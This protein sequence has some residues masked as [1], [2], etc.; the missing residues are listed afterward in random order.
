[1]LAAASARIGIATA[2]LFPTVS[3]SGRFGIGAA[4]PSDLVAAGAPFFSI[5]PSITW[6]LFDRGM[7]ARGNHPVRRI[8]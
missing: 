1:M 7:R 8:G 5:G 4:H 6:N 3:M 2:D